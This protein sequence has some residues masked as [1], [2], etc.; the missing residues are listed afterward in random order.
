M[1]LEEAPWPSEWGIPERDD[2]EVERVVKSHRDRIWH[3]APLVRSTVG[4]HLPDVRNKTNKDK[5]KPRF[6]FFG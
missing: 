1:Q 4:E 2:D 5:H 6:L 3:L